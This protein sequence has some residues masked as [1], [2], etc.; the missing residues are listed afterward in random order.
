MLSAVPMVLLTIIAF[1]VIGNI[2]VVAAF[3]RDARIRSSMANLFIV[4][5]AI[6]D[7]I[8]G[9]IVM[10]FNLVDIVKGHWSFG[11]TFCKLW[12]TLEFTLTLMSTLTMLMISW[13]RYCLLTMGIGYNTYQTKRRVGTVLSVSWITCLI[14]YGTLA[15][16]WKGLFGSGTLDYSV[17]CEMEFLTNVNATVVVNVIEFV[18]PFT[19]LLIFNFLVYIKIRRRSVGVIGDSHNINNLPDKGQRS[20]GI[21]HIDIP[22]CQPETER[23]TSD[24]DITKKFRPSHTQV[25]SPTHTSS[26]LETEELEDLPQYRSDQHTLGD[27]LDR[28]FNARIPMTDVGNIRVFTSSIPPQAIDTYQLNGR[29]IANKALKRTISKHRKAALVLT[30][31]SCCYFLCYSPYNICSIVYAICRFECTNDLVWEITSYLLWCNSAINPII[32]A[33]TNVHFRRNFRRFLFLD[34]WSCDLKICR[35]S[36]L[37]NNCCVNSFA[38]TDDETRQ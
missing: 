33:A 8:V 31:L 18:I 34:R 22:T 26:K 1:T 32:Y 17:N 30:T 3:I 14:F 11:E 16:G 38:E 23:K 25:I 24:K 4:N 5:L 9:S 15:F 19:I 7:L 28:P 35:M 12:S 6:T 37:R 10:S 2:F 21:G 36:N 27:P 29:L 13:D 20:H